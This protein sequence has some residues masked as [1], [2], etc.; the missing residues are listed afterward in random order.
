MSQ[1]PTPPELARTLV[2]DAAESGQ[3][4]ALVLAGRADWC[5]S[6]AQAVLAA[7]RRE[8]TLWVTTHPPSGETALSGAQ[9]R[10]ALGREVDVLVFDAY[11][12][13]DPDAFGAACGTIRAG[14]LLLLLCPPFADWPRFSDP[15]CARITVAP[16]TPARVTGRFLERLVTVLS[17]A[18]GVAVLGQDGRYR[19]S[20]SVPPGTHDIRRP[21]PAPYR[22]DD[23]HRAVR[24]VERV[25]RTQPARPL[26]LTS[27]R[28]RGKSAALGIAAAELLRAGLRRIVVTGPRLSACEA[29]FTHAAAQLPGASTRRGQIRWGEGR[30]AFVPP[31]A[32]W[33][34]P[35]TADLVLVDEAAAIPASLLEQFLGRY[36]RIVFVTT[37]HGY[38]G[39]GRGFDLRFRKVLDRRAPGWEA[40][41]LEA[42]V[43]W[44]PGDPLEV[45]VYRALLLDAAPA[46]E[47]CAARARVEDC[48]VERLDRDR[49]VAD[50]TTLAELF[51]LLVLAHYRTRP[52]DLRHLL[53]GPNLAIYVLRA[54]GHVIGTA[55]TAA[56]GGI[57]D[58]TARAV[59][60]GRRR[61]RGHL[62]P[63]SLAA[64][65]ALVQ[66]PRLH[67]VRIMRIAVHPAAQGRGLGARLLEA[68]VRDAAKDGADA[69]GASFGASPDS[70]KFWERAQF[71]PVRLGF[72]REHTSGTHSV[73]VLRGLSPAG[74][75]LQSAGRRRLAAD[76]VQLGGD[77]WRD[78]DARLLAALQVGTAFPPEP[79]LSPEEWEEIEAF[80]FAQRGYEAS[81]FPLAKLVHGALDRPAARAGLTRAQRRAL[82]LRVVEGCS[83]A[84]TA[85]ALGLAGRSEVLSLLRAATGVLVRHAGDAAP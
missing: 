42:P 5:L 62:I 76:L 40:L 52:Y 28:G 58:P 21:P 10:K 2:R 27:D 23:Q 15:E 22:T 1:A 13:F 71:L 79:S 69:V 75:A 34:S 68:V 35:P 51:G 47:A 73:I 77:L 37:V 59:F 80:A 26:V 11:S 39:T 44:A 46:P 17:E 61:L 60:E 6:G 33:L 25:A 49:L 67:Y 30:L 63:Q 29:V 24:A 84:E 74:E 70:L 19:A 55:V 48:T 82:E 85:T 36:P 72:T 78:V 66:A 16:Y 81:L 56:E 20:R 65:G 32:L 3:R 53:D 12:G 43:R 45:L 57:D 31:D 7:L 41:R 8:Q 9:A 64:H 38:E 18:D 83:W 4:R 54:E 50:E 14:G